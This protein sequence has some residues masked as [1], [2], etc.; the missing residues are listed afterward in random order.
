MALFLCCCS[1]ANHVQLFTTSWTAAHQASLSPT[2]SQSLPKFMSIE[3]I[4][5]PNHL[6]LCHPLLLLPSIFSNTRV[7]FSES[8]VHVNSPC[9][10]LLVM[11]EFLVEFG[12][13]GFHSGMPSSSKFVSKRKH[14]HPPTH[15]ST[16]ALSEDTIF[17]K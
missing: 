4:I 3:S 2:I 12:L 7:F 10:F 8:A 11:F 5:P 1:A 6:T 16:Y 17:T 14:R 13:T 9:A 15:T